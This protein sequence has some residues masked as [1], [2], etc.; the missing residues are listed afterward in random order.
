MTPTRA[1][2]RDG[3]VMDQKGRWDPGLSS[4]SLGYV[5]SGQYQS[6]QRTHFEFHIR[7]PS[8]AKAYPCRLMVTALPR[9]DVLLFTSRVIQNKMAAASLEVAALISSRT[10]ILSSKLA[11]SDSFPGVVLL[12]QS[13]YAQSG[14]YL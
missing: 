11:N 14:P 6:K 1:T 2:I 8:L 12:A 5:S 3:K 4:V 9:A 13:W 7:P 10:G